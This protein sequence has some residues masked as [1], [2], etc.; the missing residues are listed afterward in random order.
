[1]TMSLKDQRRDEILVVSKDLFMNQGLINTTMDN[2]ASKVG[3]SRRTLYRYY[4]TKEEIA[5]E[6]E[7]M[8]FQ[9]L[10]DYQKF[11]YKELSGTGYEKLES[12]LLK[13]ANYLENNP[14]VIKF[15]GEFD[16]YFTG[17]YPYSDLVSKFKDMISSTDYILEDI[18]SLGISDGSIRSDIDP[19]LVGLTISNT[20]LSLLQRIAL[21]D[22]HLDLEQGINSRDM[23]V[24]A[25][26]L[27]MHSLKNK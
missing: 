12:Y 17:E 19:K 13:L 5:F 3:V 4:K 2:I 7:I 22:N 15:S 16:Y 24:S 14:A 6:I 26:E 10:F 18:L 21:R 23:A 11:L 27:F 20:I 1:M 9:E 25:Y 8:L